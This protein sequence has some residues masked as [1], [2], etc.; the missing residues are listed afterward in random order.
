MEANASVWHN[1]AYCLRSEW[2]L[3]DHPGTVIS[4]LYRPLVCG[5]F[6]EPNSFRLRFDSQND[7]INFTSNSVENGNGWLTAYSLDFAKRYKEGNIYIVLKLRIGASASEYDFVFF[8]V[9]IRRVDGTS[10]RNG[11]MVDVNLVR[12]HPDRHNNSV[13]AYIACAVESPNE[14][15]PSLIGIERPKERNDVRRNIFAS[16]LNHTVKFSTRTGDGEVSR[17]RMFYAGKHSSCEGSLIKGRTET[18]DRLDGDT[19]DTGWEGLSEFDLV[20]IIDSIIVTLGYA[21]VGLAIK[22]TL[23][24]TVEIADVLLCSRDSHPGTGEG[25]VHEPSNE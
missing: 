18:F 14:V 11:H 2:S 7:A 23:D 25:V 22:E 9:P 15:I 16:T 1:P 10:A 21:C 20:K 6:T 4:W 12:C 24:P 8:A 5:L 13:F 3:A 17:S 19:C